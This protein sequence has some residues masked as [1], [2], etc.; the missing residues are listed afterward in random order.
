MI[1]V[2]AIGGFSEWRVAARRLMGGGVSPGE[3][4]WRGVDEEIGLFGGLVSAS[5]GGVDG[6]VLR[7][8][9]DGY[10][11]VPKCFVRLAET[12]ACHRSGRQWG[13]LYDLLWRV[14]REGKRGLLD[15][16]TDEVFRE[17]SGMASEIRRDIHKM[18]AFVRFRQVDTREDGREVYVAWFEP[19][20]L[21]VRVNAPFFKRR[22]A[23][24]D[25]SILT[26]DECVCWDGVGLR[27]SGGVSKDNAPDGDELEELWRMY[28][29]SIFNPARVKLK[30]MQSEMPKKYWK[31]LPEAEIISELI[32]GSSGRVDGMMAEEE[33][34]VKT[35]PKNAYLRKLGEM[36]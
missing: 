26:A 21:I 14:V 32:E 5:G 1:E 20:H 10:F 24:M 15:D 35:A 23:G 36:E 29:R 11:C 28:Y 16:M 9:G 6:L 13:L 18:R 25:W 4:I 8:E 31:N 30:M 34:E 22:F 3:V 19:E 17:L 33:R 12:V 7:E 2:D 27:F